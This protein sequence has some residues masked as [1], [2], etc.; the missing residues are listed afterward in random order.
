MGRYLAEHIPGSKYVELPGADWYPP[1]V[2]S[3]PVLE[4]I[5]E[6]LTW[7]SSRA[8]AGPDFEPPYCSPTL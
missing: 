2:N 7:R 3:E 4:E 8:G 6:F 1:F 5:E